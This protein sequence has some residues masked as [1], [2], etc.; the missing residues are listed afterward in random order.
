V[1]LVR[2][3]LSKPNVLILDEP[4][5]HLDYESVEMLETAL[6]DYSGTLVLVSHD[7]YLLERLTER[8][9][10]LEKPTTTLKVS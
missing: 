8:E 3:I 7:R 9:V 10:W 5:T 4:T 2:L 6:K 1:S